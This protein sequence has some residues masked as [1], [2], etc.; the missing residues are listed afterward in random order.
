VLQRNSG[1][2]TEIAGRRQCIYMVL[3]VYFGQDLVDRLLAW[4]GWFDMISLMR[5]LLKQITKG[6]PLLKP[7]GMTT[8]SVGNVLHN[9]SSGLM[10]LQYPS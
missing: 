9:L 2:P 7:S 3:W 5:P 6:H 4:L 8:L 1:S 10:D